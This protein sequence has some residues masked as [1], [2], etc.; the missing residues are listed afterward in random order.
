MLQSAIRNAVSR[1]FLDESTSVREAAVALVGSYV[2]QTPALA[3]AFHAP[4]LSRV[5]DPGVS[6][7]KRT[8]RI[9]RDVLLSNPAYTGRAAACSALLKRAADPKEDDG[10]RDLIHSLFHELW[11]GSGDSSIP[12]TSG[13]AMPAENKTDYSVPLNHD[14]GVGAEHDTRVGVVTPTETPVAKSTEF[15]NASSRQT[16]SHIQL[17]CD[18]AAEQMVEVVRSTGSGEILAAL[19][20]ELLSGFSDA[21]KDRK[22]AERRKRQEAAQRHCSY[23]VESLI[24]QL[25]TLDVSRSHSG[26]NAGD[27]LVAIIRTIEVFAQASPDLVLPHLDPILPYLKADNNVLPT[28]ET[29][30][31]RAACSIVA[32]LA[33]I[34]GKSE[35]RQLSEGSIGDDLLAITKSRRTG[36]IGSAV[37]ALSFL[38]NR[39]LEVNSR[40]HKKVMSLASTFYKYAYKNKNLTCDVAS[41]SV[42]CVS[43]YCL[44]VW[45]G[46]P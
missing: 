22:A 34:M 39:D 23:L 42:S 15:Q 1:R 29:A 4:L 2:L 27:K 19:M 11:L 21:E 26:E 7:R 12:L 37:Q 45:T 20:R 40:L 31:V 14:S 32:H 9:F 17:R 43:L 33:P 6:V 18:M 13:T 30:I 10:V 5:S 25:V 36:A 28:D 46:T 3:N 38:S 44:L 35:I 8:I 16:R 41:A 24:E